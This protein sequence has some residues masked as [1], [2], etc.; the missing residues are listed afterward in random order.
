MIGL[1][2]FELIRQNHGGYA[3]WA[4]WTAAGGKPKSNVGDMSIFDVTAN[5]TLL[6]A[7]KNEIIMVGL[8]ISSSSLA[9]PFRNFHSPSPKAHDFKIRYAFTDTAY[10]GAYM[11][12]IIKGVETV[13]SHALRRHLRANPSLI[14]TNVEKFREELHD[15]RAR[16]QTILAF[17]KDAHA[18]LAKHLH[19]HEYLTLIKLRHYSVRVSKEM[20]R[21]ECLA[22]C[23]KKST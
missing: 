23:G 14:K 5:P 21:E 1:E 4:V 3:S 8:N 16:S 12:D 13:D 11:T 17:G 20:Y 10:Y 18:L 9:E 6:A 19:P 2:Q 7:L 15:L 22:R